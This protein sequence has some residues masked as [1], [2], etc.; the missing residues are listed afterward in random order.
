[1]SLSNE[2][3]Y[4]WVDWELVNIL[5]MRDVCFQSIN[6]IGGMYWNMTSLCSVVP[7][8]LLNFMET[9]I[10]Y[11]CFPPTGLFGINKIDNPNPC[12]FNGSRQNLVARDI[13][14]AKLLMIEERTKLHD[15]Q[16]CGATKQ[17]WTNRNII[18]TNEDWA[19][20]SPFWTIWL[21]IHHKLHANTRVAILTTYVAPLYLWLT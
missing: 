1:M 2:W 3:I 4:D 14:M 12:T 6:N 7:I 16:K 9:H 13:Y 17:T 11:H 21:S 18:L 15:I 20:D 10:Y 8:S 5:C 19:I